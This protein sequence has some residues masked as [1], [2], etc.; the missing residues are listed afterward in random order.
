MKFLLIQTGSVLLLSFCLLMPAPVKAQGLVENGLFASTISFQ[1]PENGQ[2][3]FRITMSNLAP[4]K[5]IIDNFVIYIGPD[6]EEND[7]EAIGTITGQQLAHD[8][9][10]FL[11]TQADKELII[12]PITAVPEGRIDWDCSHLPN[13]AGDCTCPGPPND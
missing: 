8:C 12:A 5:L 1:C 9:T 11:Q 2:C 7:V 10:R 6:L 4:S 13:Y 3:N